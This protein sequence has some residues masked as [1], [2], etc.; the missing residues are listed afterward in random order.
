MAEKATDWLAFFAVLSW[1][2]PGVYAWMAD[3]SQLA[4]LLMP[5]LGCAWLGVQITLK[6]MRN[7]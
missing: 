2:K 5:V 4:A 3:F 7:K 1:L 6:L